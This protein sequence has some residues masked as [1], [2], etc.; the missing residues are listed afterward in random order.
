DDDPGLTQIQSQVAAP[1]GTV[2]GGQL[3]AVEGALF[4]DASKAAGFAGARVVFGNAF[5]FAPGSPFTFEFWVKPDAPLTSGKR[6][7]FSKYQTDTIFNGNA[8]FFFR[9]NEDGM[10]FSFEPSGFG[11]ITSVGDEAPPTTDT[12]TYVVVTSD[13]ATAMNLY[14]NALEPKRVTLELGAAGQSAPFLL[15]DVFDGER[16]RGAIDEFAVYNKELPKVR[17][18]AHY[19]AGRPPPVE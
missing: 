11:S 17:I 7:V 18:Q 5:A 10:A 16:F 19:A 3:L 1:L 4:D 8:G 13:G 12:F 2:E 9:A 14:I 15:G 6:T